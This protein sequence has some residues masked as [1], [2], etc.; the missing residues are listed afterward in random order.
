MRGRPA[1]FF[2]VDISMLL[3][4]VLTKFLWTLLQYS[5]IEIIMVHVY[6]N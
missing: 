5:R 6:H 1:I 4:G 2:S 3:G